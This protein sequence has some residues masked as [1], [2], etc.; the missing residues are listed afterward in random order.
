MKVHSFRPLLLSLAD[1]SGGS[2]KLVAIV[3]SW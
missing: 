3:Y 2:L 1:A